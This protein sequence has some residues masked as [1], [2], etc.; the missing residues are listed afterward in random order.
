MTPR[1]HLFYTTTQIPFADEDDEKFVDCAVCG[2][3]DFLITNDKNFNILKNIEFPKLKIVTADIFI[4][5]Y[6]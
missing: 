3:A 2:N 6:L 5:R 1:N 4:E